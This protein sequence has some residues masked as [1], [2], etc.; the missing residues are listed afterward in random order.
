[1]G[2]MINRRRVCGGKNLP[3]DY[4]VEYL[5][6]NG[7]AYITDNITTLSTY[8]H[9]CCFN[10]HSVTSINWVRI[11]CADYVTVVWAKPEQRY[12]SVFVSCGKETIMAEQVILNNKKTT[13]TVTDENNFRVKY[14]NIDKIYTVRKGTKSTSSVFY[15]FNNVTDRKGSVSIYY[16]KIW[17]EN[18]NLVRS[19][20]PVVKEGVGYMYDKVSGTLFGNT[21]TGSFIAGPRVS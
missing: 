10:V 20:I 19:Y 6:N 13:I 9:E 16:H 17:D 18:G 7:C 1:M 12:N 21:G 11:F 14:E 8:K 5:T 4:E 2:M 15:L 3:Y